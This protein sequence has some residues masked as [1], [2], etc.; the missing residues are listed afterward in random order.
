M[1]KITHILAATDLS[2]SSLEAVDRSLL[3]AATLGARCTVLHA[4]GLDALAPL[5]ALLG[6]RAEAVS[7][8]LL[9]QARAELAQ[10]VAESRQARGLDPV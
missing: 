8:Q 1:S 10:A 9:A 3:L 6:A 4:L 2:A 5:R 7:D